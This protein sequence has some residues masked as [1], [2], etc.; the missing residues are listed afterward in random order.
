T[1]YGDFAAGELA[2]RVNTAER[3]E[4][5]V[6]KWA[7]HA[8]GR[9]TVA[10]TCDIQHA[11]DLAEVFRSGGF[12]A[13]AVHGGTPT[14]QRRDALAAL[15]SGSLDVL[16]NCNLL[17][18]GWDSPAVSC[19]VMARPTKSRGLYQQMIGRIL[20]PADGKVDALVLDVTDNAKRHKLVTV[21]SL[22]GVERSDLAGLTVDEAERDED[23]EREAKTSAREHDEE[24]DASPPVMLDGYLPT[25]AWHRWP[26]TD[27]QLAAIARHGID[28]GGY[29]LTRGEAAYLLDKAIQTKLAGPPTGKQAWRLRQ[30]GIDPRGLTFRQASELIAELQEAAA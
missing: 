3:N 2:V 1:S 5:V 14:D 15:A 16:C 25:A 6:G 20:R 4:I 11:H 22:F 10:F 30:S 7:E 27:K 8:Y 9:K 19:V 12:A 18:E 28:V 23:A 29:V 21:S 17:T 24:I 26:A 13:A